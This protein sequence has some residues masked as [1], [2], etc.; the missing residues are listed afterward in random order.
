MFY[1]EECAE[2]EGW[3]YLSTRSRGPCEICGE[4][5]ICTDVPSRS[6]PAKQPDKPE[7]KHTPGPLTRIRSRKHPGVIFFKQPFKQSQT[8]DNFVCKFYPNHEGDASLFEAAPDLLAACEDMHNQLVRMVEKWPHGTISMGK[9]E[10][11][12]HKAEGGK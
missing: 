6:L 12:I 7:T 2:K 3:P 11:A 8:E 1:C 5:K 9:M 10:R 4:T